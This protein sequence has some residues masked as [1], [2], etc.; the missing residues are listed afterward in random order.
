VIYQIGD[1]VVSRK[2][3]AGL[4]SMFQQGWVIAPLRP[5]E[6]SVLLKF[7]YLLFTLADNR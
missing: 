2:K 1:L 4:G 5:L 7:L 3:R 6:S